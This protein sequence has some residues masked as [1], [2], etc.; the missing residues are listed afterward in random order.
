MQKNNII[1]N[2]QTA[3]DNK[4]YENALQQIEDTIKFITFDFYYREPVQSTQKFDSIC[5]KIGQSTLIKT[6]NPHY[7]TETIVYI[8]SE[9]YLTGGHTLCL[10]SFIDAQ[11]NKKHIILLTAQNK[12]DINKLK[13]V[14]F[15]S[16]NTTIFCYEN[17]SKKIMPRIKWLQ[18]KLLEI[19]PFHCFLFNH[20]YDTSIIA[21][22]QPY[23]A[24][25]FYLYHHSD[26][27]PNIGLN[28]DHINVISIFE[29]EYW[30]L[31]QFISLK[32][33]C[34]IPLMF[35]ESKTPIK[36]NLKK[37]DKIISASSTADKYK[38]QLPY[39]YTFEDSVIKLLKKT[40]GT[41]ILIG[42]FPA[43]II[44]NIIKKISQF[45]LSK[46]NLIHIPWVPNLGNSLE[47]LNVTL[48]LTTTPSVGG[49]TLTEV[50]SK[51]IP[52]I[53]HSCYTSKKLRMSDLTY[54]EA[55]IWKNNSEFDTILSQ[56]NYEILKK[57]H[58][59][60]INH[61]NK[62][63]NQNHLSL[64]LNKEKIIGKKID[65]KTLNTTIHIQNDQ[66]NQN[67][68]LIYLDRLDHE[69]IRIKKENLL[70]TYINNTKNKLKKYYIHLIYIIK[71]KNQTTTIQ[72]T[73]NKL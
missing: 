51:G 15:S 43:S 6:P 36:Y 44:I 68:L 18:K 47:E 23:L 71:Y 13:K 7:N 49:L 33:L 5:H 63:H 32:R 39:H 64:Y 25:Q 48:Y 17:S 34:F 29:Y 69:H 11:P 37:E 55:Y 60:S 10:K 1:H 21:A 20:P 35:P 58:K 52:I 30:R 31:S 22:T 54:P 19:R 72:K 8:A 42:D 66:N 12:K 62:T 46:K 53:K 9:L 73:I 40:K 3:Y 59:F 26:C 2:I 38:I 65:L 70:I 14:R 16:K 27:S 4:N 41:H 56:L 45:G 24:N 67:E 28:L 61:F 50:M 57:H